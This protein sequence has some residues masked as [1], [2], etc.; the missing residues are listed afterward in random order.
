MG[1]I[2]VNGISYGG[3][4]SLA[5][6]VKYDGSTVSQELNRM[7]ETDK[8][9]MGSDEFDESKSYS[10]SDMC[11]YDN[12][13]W[14]CLISCVGQTPSEGTYWT[15]ISLSNAISKE[16]VLIKEFSDAGA[17]LT[18]SARS[19]VLSN[20][21][22]SYSELKLLIYSNGYAGHRTYFMDI[23]NTDKQAFVDVINVPQSSPI[24]IDFRQFS[25]NK[26]TKS[27]NI[28]QGYRWQYGSSS[29]TA[30]AGVIKVHKIYAR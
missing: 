9:I 19:E 23:K 28:G 13:L 27:F 30:S 4:S 16:W 21:L 12:K 14:K 10:V 5:S 3:S 17:G 8:N 20:I 6:N 18:Q 15:N 7:N 2:V 1:K 25:Y 24:I 29:S 22:D 11:V 26:I